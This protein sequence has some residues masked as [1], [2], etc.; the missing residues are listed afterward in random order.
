MSPPVDLAFT[1]S[2]CIV[3]WIRKP[4]AKGLQWM[5]DASSVIYASRVQRCEELSCDDVN[6][7]VYVMLP[8][9][10]VLWKR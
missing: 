1:L 6:N 3:H 7:M 2:C 9:H 10:S 5:V 8:T 4:P